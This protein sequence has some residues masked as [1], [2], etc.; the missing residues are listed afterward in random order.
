MVVTPY[1]SGTAATADP[2]ASGYTE[3][4]AADAFEST[5]R[6]AQRGQEN[7]L[8][9]LHEAQARRMVPG[10]ANRAGARAEGA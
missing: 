8:H 4:V 7:A 2:R 9:G 5:V 1:H 10:G 6:Q 3:E